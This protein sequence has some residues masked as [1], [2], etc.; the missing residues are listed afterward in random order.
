MIPQTLI[1]LFKCV[2]LGLELDSAGYRHCRTDVAYP[3]A[4]RIPFVCKENK[5]ND[6]I[7]QFLLFHACGAADA[8]AGGCARRGRRVNM[9]KDLDRGWLYIFCPAFVQTRIYNRDG[10][11]TS[12]RRLL[13]QQHLTASLNKVILFLFYFCY[14]KYSHSLIKLRLN[15]WCHMDYFND[16]LITFQ[17]LEHSSHVAVYAG[18][19]TQ[20]S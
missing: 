18:S 6:F 4:T 9:S 14:K 1:S 8:R 19:K 5:N 2:W 11:S 17:G 15:H 20:I 10:L 12:E 7:Q 3:L 13:C 16:V